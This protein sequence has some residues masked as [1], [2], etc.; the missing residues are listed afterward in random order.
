MEVTPKGH[1]VFD[2]IYGFI[3]LTSTEWE[4]VSQKCTYVGIES[5]I[6]TESTTDPLTVNIGDN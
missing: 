5:E 3:K 6:I 1:V 4:I 2:P